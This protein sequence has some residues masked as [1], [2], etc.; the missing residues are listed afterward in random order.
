[1]RLA[2]FNVENMFERAAAMNL[3]TWADGKQVQCSWD[4]L[5]HISRPPAE[6]LIR[7]KR[8]G[9]DRGVLLFCPGSPLLFLFT[10]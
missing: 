10:D 9:P 8:Y 6:I 2:T 5:S 7:E 1:M 4:G 3:P